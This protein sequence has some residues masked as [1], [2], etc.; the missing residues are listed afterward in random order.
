MFADWYKGFAWRLSVLLA[1]CLLAPVLAHAHGAKMEYKMAP[2]ISLKAMYDSGE[3]MA[4]AQ[5]IVFAPSDPAKPWLTGKTDKQGRFTFT[6][7]HSIAG[8]WA[9]QA[10]QAGHGAMAHINIGGSDA[11]AAAS[12]AAAPAQTGQVQTTGQS[13]TQK[14]F[15]IAA[16]V[17]GFIGTGL[18]FARKRK[19]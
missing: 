15:M 7:D 9:V 10:R 16:V 2:A 3:P 18:F 19:N 5:I 14:I 11:D 13:S 8:E 6:P 4:E 12:S 1:A 17:W